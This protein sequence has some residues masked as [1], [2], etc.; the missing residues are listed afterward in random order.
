MLMW[1]NILGKSD[2]WHYVQ[3]LCSKV[4]KLLSNGCCVCVCICYLWN[5]NNH[6][7]HYKSHVSVFWALQ[8]IENKSFGFDWLL[9]SRMSLLI[10]ELPC[11]LLFNFF[12][13]AKP[14]HLEWPQSSWVTAWGK[15]LTS[16]HNFIERTLCSLAASFLNEHDAC[17]LFSII[18]DR[19]S[20][21]YIAQLL[22]SVPVWWLCPTTG[23]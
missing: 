19:Q 22:T 3:C 10:S 5:H 2:Y 6:C 18:Q 16:H 17:P 12:C 15:N 11:R 20:D 13:F 8:R 4:Q 21:V 1:L 14:K 23:S 7:V 9:N